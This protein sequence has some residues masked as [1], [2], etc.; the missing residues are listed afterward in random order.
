MCPHQHVEAVWCRQRLPVGG[1]GLAE[2]FPCTVDVM[3]NTPL[4]QVGTLARGFG[5]RLCESACMFH[6]R[7]LQAAAPARGP[8]ELYPCLLSFAPELRQEAEYLASGVRWGCHH[9]G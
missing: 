1:E 9:W 4:S 5:A 7:H 2:N 6:L 8:T 3:E